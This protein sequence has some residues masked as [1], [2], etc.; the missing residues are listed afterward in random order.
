MTYS[1]RFWSGLVYFVTVFALLVLRILFNLGLFSALTGQ[2]YDAAWTVLAQVVCMGIIPC[3]GFLA[4]SRAEGKKPF[5][6]LVTRFGYNKNASRENWSRTVLVAILMVFTASFVSVVWSN[7]LSSIGFVRSSSAETEYSSV[8]VLIF[9]ILLVAVFPAVFEEFTHRGF[10]FGG[11]GTKNYGGKIIILSALLF[12]LMHQNIRQTAYTFYDGLIL[13]ALVYYSGSIYPA[14]FVHFFNNLI[15]VLMDY[16]AQKGGVLNIMNIISSMLTSSVW[17]M[18]V[19]LVLVAVAI[20]LLVEIFKGM[21]K[22]SLEKYPIQL[23]DVVV[24]VDRK[25]DLQR[26]IFGKKPHKVTWREDIFLYGAII[27]SAMATV[28]T[29]VWGLLR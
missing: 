10:L 28:F 25:F 16:G 18:L 2:A 11:Y 4:I 3:V 20:W 5:A 1:R 8:S 23:F 26:D 17:G 9:E 22:D 29:L 12:A 14:M 19:Y 7:F 24:Y 13:G 21:R 27:M 6:T 15:S